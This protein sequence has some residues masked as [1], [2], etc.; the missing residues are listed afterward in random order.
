MK[1]TQFEAV[2]IAMKQDKSGYV[3]TL[4]MHPDEI[5]DELLRDFV[6]ARY[7]VVMVRLNEAEKPLAREQ[8]YSRDL[9]RSSAILCR[10][11]LFHKFLLAKSQI[12][13]ASEEEATDWLKT[14]LQIGSRTEL[15]N[16][17]DAA[18]QYNFIYQEFLE[19]KRN[20]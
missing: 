6:G 3:L 18:K 11:P 10:D 1:T 7:Q 12:L 16:N 19:W 17:P 14:E 13:E 9:V 8:E 5:P 20:A 15:K 4:A 2:K